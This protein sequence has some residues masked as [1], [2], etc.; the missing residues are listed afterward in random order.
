MVQDGAKKKNKNKKKN[1]KKNQPSAQES[2]SSE[3]VVQEPATVV[4][5]AVP[6]TNV[7]NVEPPKKLVNG[8]KN[9]NSAAVL[10]NMASEAD[11][12][13]TYN[14]AAIHD[15]ESK[16]QAYLASQRKGT[17]KVA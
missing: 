15:A 4:T 5:E 12:L 9:S 1:G 2:S 13:L 3:P 16:Y 6:T 7:A 11:R 17:S 8:L 10:K 14:W